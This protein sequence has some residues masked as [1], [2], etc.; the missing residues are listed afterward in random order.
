[1]K[2]CWEERRETDLFA[3]QSVFIENI[4]LLFYYLN[5]SI[6]SRHKINKYRKKWVDSHKFY[7]LTF[8]VSVLQSSVYLP[9][10]LNLPTLC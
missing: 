5:K 10:L 2:L 6:K 8:I 9:L 3:N 4:T 7:Q 1:M